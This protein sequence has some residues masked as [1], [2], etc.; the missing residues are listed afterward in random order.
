M[1][2]YILSLLLVLSVVAYGMAQTTF[3]NATNT[4]TLARLNAATAT[5]DTVTDTGAGA[6][7]TKLQTGNG[8]VTVQ[9]NVQKVSGTVAGTAVLSGSLDGVY[10]TAL[11]T[12]ETQTALPTI[13]L[14]NTTGTVSY[15]WR[16]RDSPYLYYKVGTSGGTT[17]VYYLTAF[18]RR[19]GIDH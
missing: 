11:S 12:E 13:T 17:C 2:R 10:Y 16:L 7:Y 19:S 5:R 3:Y 8:Y 15:S 4:Y 18:I 14:T 6:L 1:K 9:V